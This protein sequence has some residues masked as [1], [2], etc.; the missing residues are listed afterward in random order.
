M[1]VY[2]AAPFMRRA[3]ARAARSVLAEHGIESTARWIDTHLEE[4][5]PDDVAR[6]EALED[7]LDVHRA[8]GFVLLHDGDLAKEGQGKHI[9]FGFA[10]AKGKLVWLVGEPTSIF[11]YH[12]NVTCVPTIEDAIWAMRRVA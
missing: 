9:E 1:T 10:L 5:I 6:N 4:G 3:E 7:L 12:P 8:E 2:I 11:H